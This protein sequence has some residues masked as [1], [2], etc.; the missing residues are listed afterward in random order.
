MMKRSSAAVWFILCLLV[1][2][3]CSST[4]SGTIAV[5]ELQ[6]NPIKYLGQHVA[7]VGTADIHTE[8]LAPQMLKLCHKYDCIWVSR[9]ESTYY[10]DQGRLIRVTGTFQ[11][12]RFNLIGEVY[13]IE[14]DDID[15]E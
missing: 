1:S 5:S 15:V 7:V 10:P 2:F 13:Y 3:G 11:Q 6:K 14:A 8:S 4:P 9:P 12:K